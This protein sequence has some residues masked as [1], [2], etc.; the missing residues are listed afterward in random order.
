MFILM[1]LDFN[2]ATVAVVSQPFI[3]HTANSKNSFEHIPDFLVVSA[4]EEIM[5]IDVKPKKFV[6]TA[7]NVRKFEATAAA[8]ELVGWDYAVQSEPNRSFLENLRWLAGYRRRFP[9]VDL[10]AEKLIKT[11]EKEP[12][13]LQDLV[14]RV[15]PPILVRPILFHLLWHRLLEINMHAQLNNK[16]LVNLPKEAFHSGA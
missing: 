4:T 12:L 14:S 3:L 2:P 16:T 11:C 13:P 8:C 5:V 10:Y 1:Q 15:G 6:A 7:E 9:T